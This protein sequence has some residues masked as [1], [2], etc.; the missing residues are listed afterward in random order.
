VIWTDSEGREWEIV[1]FHRP[2]L[3]TA[4]RLEL[5]SHK[6]EGRAFVPRE[7][8]GPTLIYNFGRI[9]YRDT[10]DRTL[11]NQLAYAK[12]AHVGSGK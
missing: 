8:E 9:A 10:G 4:K 12:P 11:R 5:G 2:D 7:R 1:D 3:K 6:A